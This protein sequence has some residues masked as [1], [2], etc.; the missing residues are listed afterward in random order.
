VHAI[1]FLAARWFR[2]QR[3][4]YRQF[5]GGG[6]NEGETKKR[7]DN[8]TAIQKLIKRKR[9]GEKCSQTKAVQEEKRMSPN[10]DINE[11]GW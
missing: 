3:D 7:K 4:T 10:E 1:K 2:G 8:L 6:K 9:V 11:D 5:V